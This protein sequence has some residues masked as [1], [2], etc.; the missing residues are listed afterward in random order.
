MQRGAEKK[1]KQNIRLWLLCL[2][3]VILVS[4]ASSIVRAA[5]EN[6]KSTAVRA[7]HVK[8]SEIEASTLIIGSHLIHISALTTE[9]YNTA[10]ESA[11]EFNQ[12]QV[13]YKSELANGGWFEITDATSIADI[14][15]AGTPVS[16]SVI[17]NLD[18]THHTKSDGITI[19]LRSGQ[20]V[21]VCDITNPYD[22]NSMEE[23]EP[24]RL[25]YQILQEK[26]KKTDSDDAYLKMI[27]EFFGKSI[28]NES[29]DECDEALTALGN[30]KNG[31]P[32]RDKPSRWVEKTE[33]IMVSVDA[34][35]RVISLS[36]LADNL[37]ALESLACGFPKPPEEKEETEEGSEEEEEEEEEEPDDL[38]LNS[39]IIAAIGDSIKN[40]QQSI[41]SYEAKM[42]T[43]SGET[44]S[45]KAEYRYQQELITRAKNEDTPGCDEMM[46]MLCNLENILDDVIADQKSELN[47]LT[48]DLVN[49][50]YTK[51]MGDLKA[52]VSQDYQTA[53]AEGAAAS[54]LSNHLSSQKAAANADRLEYQTLLE[55]QFKRM[56]NK[57][58]QEYNLQLIDGIPA[59]EATILSDPAQSYLKE[60]VQEHLIW[61]RNTYSELVKNGLDATDMSK[62][63]KEKEDLA[64][65]RQDALD[66]NDLA[67]ANKLTAEMEAKQKDMDALANRLNNILNSTN[68]SEADKARAAAGMGDTNTAALLGNMADTLASGIRSSDSDNAD[69]ANQ[70]AALSAASQLDP[71]AG[72]AALGQVQD[73]LNGA[74]E[75]DADAKASLND[76]LSD[77]L[78]DNKAALAS[79]AGSGDLSG[80]SADELAN[81][82]D[83]ILAALLGTSFAEASSSQQA[84]AM[85]A[86]DWFGERKNSAGA[87]E[88]AA[89]LAKQT[90]QSNNP[91]LYEKYQGK[92]DAYLSLQAYGKVMGFRYI[93]DD[94]HNT[95]TLQKSKD[96]FVFTLAKKEYEMTGKTKKNLETAPELQGTLYIKEGDSTKIFETKAEYIEKAK[97]GVVVTA[98]VETLAKE[99]YD[100]LVEGGV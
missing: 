68:S 32:E 92:K 33:E 100:K 78:D 77:A 47:T 39:D 53:R 6:E 4:G 44:A 94:K 66:N 89:T 16:K 37:E 85:I 17:E 71:E 72:Q 13:Y 80:L 43:D 73:A 21:S 76:S 48:S 5:L 49:A 83:D 62:L 59:M 26:E 96:Y 2:T 34:K 84:A 93:F 30:Y 12:N 64:K 24:I 23:L 74:T 95:V 56:E 90:A 87:L 98:P 99:I 50:A 25:Q 57:A 14:T 54:V 35:R 45:A 65:K 10:L 67:G 7:V 60:T 91:Y 97:Y 70:L 46:E 38:V 27:G 20:A 15:T 55:A 31:L 81:A 79:G 1:K 19:D 28:Q 8:D 52:G 22:L 75:L 63:E 61:L 36:I 69:L 82:L 51:Y 18:L 41:A 40:V 88:L 9:L 11:N 86:M 42:L 3:A 58:A 29:T